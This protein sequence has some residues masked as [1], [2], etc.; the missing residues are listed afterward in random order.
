MAAFLVVDLVVHDMQQYID[1]GY[2]ADV[3]KIAAKYGGKY[4]ARGG[5]VEQL[6][7]DWLPSRMVIIEFPDM[8]SLKAFYH[9][10]EYRP[11]IKIRQ[12]LTDTNLI[13]VEGLA[14]PL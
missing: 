6:E 11:Y 4:R 10:D 2:I 7:G 3:P 1:S 13:A 5:A 9:C 14:E 8:D 12:G